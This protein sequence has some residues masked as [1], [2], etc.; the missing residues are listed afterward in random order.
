MSSAMESMF[1]AYSMYSAGLGSLPGGGAEILVDRVRK[2]LT[3][4][5][6]MTDDWLNLGKT[7]PNAWPFFT[8]QEAMAAQQAAAGARAATQVSTDR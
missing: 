5:K 1:L 8:N 7:Q 3:R 6:V 4:G 2:E